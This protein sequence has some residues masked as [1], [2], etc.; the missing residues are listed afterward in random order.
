MPRRIIIINVLLFAALFG[1]VSLNKEFI[2]PALENKGFSGLLSGCF[3]NFIAAF[4]IS[5]CK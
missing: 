4:L 3:P 1:L 5:A 2:R